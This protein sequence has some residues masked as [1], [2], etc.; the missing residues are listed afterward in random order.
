MVTLSIILIIIR[1]LHVNNAGLC[2]HNFL[3]CSYLRKY[4]PVPVV[5]IDNEL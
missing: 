3:A 1:Q 2:E 5:V 4:K